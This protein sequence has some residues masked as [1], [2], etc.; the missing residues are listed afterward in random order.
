MQLSLLSLTASNRCQIG[1]NVGHASC[2]ASPRHPQ[3][4][5]ARSPAGHPARPCLP[6]GMHPERHL[7]AGNQAVPGEPG[8]PAR[9]QPHPA[10]GGAADAAGGRP[11]RNRAEPADPGSGPGS[12]RTRRGLRQPDPAGDAG[13]VDDHRAFRG[14]GPQRG[15]ADADRD[16]AGRQERRLR[17]LVRGTHRVS[18]GLHGGGR[19]RDAAAT[20]GLRRPD[21][22]L[23]PHLSAVRAGQLAGGRRRRARR[24]PGGADRRARAGRAERDGAPPGTD[25]TAGADRL[26]ARLRAGGGAARGGAH[27]PPARPAAA[28]RSE[29]SCA[30][31]ADRLAPEAG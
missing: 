18:P 19:R 6:A 13:A 14:Q 23:H 24:D 22:P 25:G 29:L 28:D 15:Q 26:R 4:R 9:H 12:G 3:G 7:V 10:P 11:G 5:L 30:G 31:P 16:A 1:E 8:R 27:R 21:H 20:A 2:R 17:R